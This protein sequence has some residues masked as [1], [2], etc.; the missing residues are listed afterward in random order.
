MHDCQQLRKKCIEFALSEISNSFS[1]LE[2]DTLPQTLQ[3][4]LF[5][6]KA[7]RDRIISK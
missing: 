2:Y 1:H 4:E 7:E 3:K 6:A 5:E